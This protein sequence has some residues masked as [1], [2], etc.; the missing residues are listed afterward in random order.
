MVE[1]FVL[2]V[3]EQVTYMITI[4]VIN[5]FMVVSLSVYLCLHVCVCAV[6]VCASMNFVSVVFTLVYKTM[7]IVNVFFNI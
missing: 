1:H 7:Y 5:G 3:T 2:E 6:G 4:A